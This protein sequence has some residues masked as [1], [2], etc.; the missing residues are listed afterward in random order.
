MRANDRGG[1]ILP[2]P[3]A[4]ASEGIKFV[5]E[6]RNHN[7]NKEIR[8]P[9]FSREKYSRTFGAQN[10]YY[11]YGNIKWKKC[12]HLDEYEFQY[13][14]IHNKRVQSIFDVNKPVYV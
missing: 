5:N 1:S 3:K 6:I 13:G 9:Y 14:Q 10:V 12:L 4:G 8:M 11:Y 2:L 7:V